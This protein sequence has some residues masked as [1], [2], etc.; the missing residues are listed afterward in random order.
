VDAAEVNGRLFLNNSSLGIYPFLVQDRERRQ[1]AHGLTKWIAAFLASFRMLW[2]FPVRRLTVTAEGET[3]PHRTP[4][5]FVGNN[6]YRLDSP[7]FAERKRL[8]AGELWVCI[9]K[10]ESRFGL[11]GLA[12]R[13]IFG[14]VNVEH[15]LETMHTASVEILSRA[16]RLPVAF[17]GEVDV[18]RPP[19]RYRVR[20]SALTVIS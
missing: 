16:T 1:S 15:D 3:R 6:E 19:L 13:R 10:A 9:S 2:Q 20:P 4:L 5:L 8:D 12:L 17:D 14:S 18:M 11:V 7:G